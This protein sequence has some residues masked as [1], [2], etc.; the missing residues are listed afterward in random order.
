LP[1]RVPGIN[2]AAHVAIGSGFLCAAL[3]DKTVK[4]WGFNSNGQLGIGSTD[5]AFHSSATV[6]TGP[7]APLTNVVQLAASSTF[8]CALTADHAAW[9]WGYTGN[10]GSGLAG[11]SGASAPFAAPVCARD[12]ANQSCAA[13]NDVLE[14]AVADEHVCYRA[15]GGAVACWGLNNFGNCGQPGGAVNQPKTIAGLTANRIAVG[16]LTSCAVLGDGSSLVACW[17]S[18]VDGQL[19]AGTVDTDT[20][21]SPSPVC[22]GSGC[23]PQQGAWVAIGQQ[24]A[25]TLYM[26]NVSCWGRNSHGQLLTGD[27]VDHFYADFLNVISSTAEQITAGALFSCINDSAFGPSC[28]GADDQHQLGN[29]D[30]ADSPFRVPPPL[31]N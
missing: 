14:V 19:G 7:G 29:G 24:H 11:V 30:T 17:G 9:C 6:L 22:T 27:K 2:S 13:A 15:V 5:F 26:G 28:W 8:T 10:I 21:P 20:H 16:A 23:A 1:V 3:A 12:S 31:G 18:N 25:C 4:C